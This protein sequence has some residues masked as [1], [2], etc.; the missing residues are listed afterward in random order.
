VAS[1][2]PGGFRHLRARPKDCA[3]WLADGADLWSTAAT[4]L[5]HDDR[6]TIIDVTFQPPPQARSFPVE[7]VR[8]VVSDEGDV[9]AVPVDA[10]GRTWEHRYTR[11]TLAS[12]LAS[13]CP[14]DWHFILGALCLWYPYD[15]TR[16][17]WTWRLG[18]DGY[19]RL[20][21]KHLWS[22]EYSRRH[23]FWPAEAA[24]HGQRDDDLPHPIMT[25]DLRSAA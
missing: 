13:E 24:P 2:K 5:L 11:S 20:V 15:P 9:Y 19:L 22:E 12:L 18:L 14:V 6:V 25:A 3:R 7:V 17:R 1:V 10:D 21:Q 23:G 4:V 8:I 16:L